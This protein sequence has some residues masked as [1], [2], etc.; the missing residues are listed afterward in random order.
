MKGLFSILKPSLPTLVHIRIE[1]FDETD[2]ETDD[3]TD[4]GPLTSLCHELEKIVGQ[5]FIETIEILIWVQPL[6]GWGGKRWCE[7]QEVIIGSLEGW[8]A[9]RNVSLSVHVIIYDPE[10]K[11]FEEIY[12]TKLVESKQLLFELEV[13]PIRVNS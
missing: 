1:Y 10:D 5:N 12:I 2:D 3:K 9:L 7:L 4:D 13:K 11:G 6:V 8:P